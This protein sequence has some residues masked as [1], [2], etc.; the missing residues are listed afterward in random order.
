M[1]A[2]W[3]IGLATW[4]AIIG[5]AFG[6]AWFADPFRKEKENRQKMLKACSWHGDGHGVHCGMCGDHLTVENIG[7]LDEDGNGYCYLHTKEAGK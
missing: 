4:F 5:G 3:I 6:F 7:G 2:D 1:S